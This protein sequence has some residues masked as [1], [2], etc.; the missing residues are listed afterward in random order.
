MSSEGCTPIEVPALLQLNDL[1]LVFRCHEVVLTFLPSILPPGVRF[2]VE[3]IP[4]CHHHPSNCYP[5]FGIFRAES[6][7]QVE[8]TKA[9]IDAWIAA[10]GIDWLIAK[11]SEITAPTWE[12][13]RARR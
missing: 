10:Q 11:S 3:T 2:R 8:D 6:W 9:R 13:F 4:F 1:D 12:E 7:D 5:A